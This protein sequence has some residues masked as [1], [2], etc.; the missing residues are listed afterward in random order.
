M[1]LSSAS[2]G[3]VLLLCSCQGWHS[4][5]PCPVRDLLIQEMIPEAVHVQDGTSWCPW[6]PL[7]LRPRGGRGAAWRH[8][9]SQRGTE[10]AGDSRSRS[11][12]QNGI[13]TELSG[14]C[15][16][17][18]HVASSQ[19]P[20]F[21]RHPR[22]C[23]KAQLPKPPPVQHRPNQPINNRTETL[24]IKTMNHRLRSQ[25]RAM[26]ALP[27]NLNT[28]TGSW[29]S[30]PAAAPG[31][32]PHPAS[33]GQPIITFPSQIPL[34]SQAFKK[35]KLLSPGV[36]SW[37]GTAEL[38][39]TLFISKVT[40]GQPGQGRRPEGTRQPQRSSSW[41]LSPSTHMGKTP[42]SSGEHTHCTNPSP[43]HVPAPLCSL[44]CCNPLPSPPNPWASPKSCSPRAARTR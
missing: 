12:V 2:P 36:S 17:L 15:G 29:S 41:A 23:H 43:H 21:R 27:Q 13:Q 33:K 38:P 37:P 40:P 7:A 42:K 1:W 14:F 22:H 11:V 8:R 3:A 26:Q 10:A 35:K 9:D 28:W 44:P 34:R 18:P 5:I 24:P 6:L 20:P 31:L 30:P 25:P 19:P 16:R 32:S 39:R 4:V